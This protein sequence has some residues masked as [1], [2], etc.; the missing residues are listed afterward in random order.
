MEAKT[1]KGPFPEGD[2]L[3][4]SL[5]REPPFLKEGCDGRPEITLNL[6][7]AFF[8]CPTRAAGGLDLA[9]EFHHFFGA[10]GKSIQDG[11]GFTAPSLLFN[12]E[13]DGFQF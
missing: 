1:R 10:A 8:H 3:S 13:V 4:A 6:H 12:P 9:G 2:G 7:T 5:H 11:D